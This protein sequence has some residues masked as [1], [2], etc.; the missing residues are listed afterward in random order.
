[1]RKLLGRFYD[2]CVES[3]QL[4]T[5]SLAALKPIPDLP[6]TRQ[7]RSRNRVSG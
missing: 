3:F 4:I 1:M 7:P 2:A 5:N 6:D